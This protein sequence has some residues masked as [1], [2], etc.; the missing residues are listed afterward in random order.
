MHAAKSLHMKTACVTLTCLVS[1]VI[2]CV[3]TPCLPPAL[4][5][6]SLLLHGFPH[7]TASYFSARCNIGLSVVLPRLSAAAPRLPIFHFLYYSMSQRE[8][9][10]RE[11]EG[12]CL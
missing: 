7:T 1:K 5:I 11:S 2:C 8:H 10:E 6:Q 9:Y 3:I 12:L 4:E